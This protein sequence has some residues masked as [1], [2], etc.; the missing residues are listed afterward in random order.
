MPSRKDYERILEPDLSESDDSVDEMVDGLAHWVSELGELTTAH[1][2]PPAL[3]IREVPDPPVF[4][5]P[6]K[7]F[8]RQK[9]ETKRDAAERRVLD[10]LYSGY[11]D[12]KTRAADLDNDAIICLGGS[13]A[14]NRSI[15]VA[16]LE[17]EFDFDWYST[18]FFTGEKTDHSGVRLHLVLLNRSSRTALGR[19]A[20]ASNSMLIDDRGHQ[21]S[22]ESLSMMWDDEDGEWHNHPELLA[23]GSRMDGFLLFPELRQGSGAFRRWY[24]N[25]TASRVGTSVQIDFDIPL[26]NGLHY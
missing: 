1:P 23:P 17:L 20:P 2:G 18:S 6:P 19:V 7:E 10:E 5:D 3:T 13:Y 21:Y 14:F 12:A 11:E 24:W 16:V 25:E 8:G 9:V 4:A 15:A 22:P 26:K